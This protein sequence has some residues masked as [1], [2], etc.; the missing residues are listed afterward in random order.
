MD[1]IRLTMPTVESSPIEID[2]FNRLIAIKQLRLHPL[3]SSHPE[4][5]YDGNQ[6]Y[7]QAV[8]SFNELNR[9]TLIT[10]LQSHPQAKSNPEIN[11]R[12]DQTYEE[13]EESFDTLNSIHI[14]NGNQLFDRNGSLDLDDIII[15]RWIYRQPFK[16]ITPAEQQEET[17][18]RVRVLPIPTE[19]ERGLIPEITL[20]TLKKGEGDKLEVCP[21][22]SEGRAVVYTCT[23]GHITC[24]SCIC[25]MISNINS[26]E[27]NIDKINK[28]IQEE[29]A[30]CTIARDAHNLSE[31]DYHQEILRI[32]GNF[33]AQLASLRGKKKDLERGIK[34]IECPICRTNAQFLKKYLKH[35]K[36]KKFI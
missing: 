17:R 12:Y 28:E 27:K 25:G 24:P 30:H 4:F 31:Q 9:L 2:E 6:S 10:R 7:E 16:S 29:L 19:F 33:D 34:I 18:I 8:A 36:T 11:Y 35:K 20:V 21:I 32:S 5:D 13:A 15:D 3:A 23:N 26:I 1:P 22:C 14:S